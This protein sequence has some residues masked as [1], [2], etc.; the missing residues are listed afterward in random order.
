MKEEDDVDGKKAKGGGKGGGWEEKE[1]RGEVGRG[2]ENLL[3]TLR[4]ICLEGDAPFSGYQLVII[5]YTIS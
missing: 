4:V 2:L 3:M 1:E 5:I